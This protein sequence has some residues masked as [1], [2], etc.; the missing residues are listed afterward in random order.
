MKGKKKEK[1]LTKENTFDN[2]FHLSI[3]WKNIDIQVFVISFITLLFKWLTTKNQMSWKIVI[4]IARISA[5][6]H[7]F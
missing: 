3:V 5:K 6:C 4:N 2:M 7:H 1:N